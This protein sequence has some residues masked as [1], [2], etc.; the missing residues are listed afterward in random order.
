MTQMKNLWY[1]KHV[2]KCRFGMNDWRA[3]GSS[4]QALKK[5]FPVYARVFCAIAAR[6]NN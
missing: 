2:F 6:F 5:L 1:T 4:L 3:S